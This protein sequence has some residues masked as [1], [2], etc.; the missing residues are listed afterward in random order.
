ML[1]KKTPKARERRKRQL[2]RLGYG[3]DLIKDIIDIEFGMKSMHKAPG[4]PLPGKKY[5]KGGIVRIF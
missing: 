5:N 1:K 4:T 3:D 2:G